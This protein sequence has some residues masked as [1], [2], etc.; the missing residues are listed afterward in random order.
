MLPYSCFR[1]E[2]RGF[3]A[4]CNSILLQYKRFRAYGA[5]SKHTLLQ[6]D[7]YQFTPDRGSPLRGPNL[8]AHNN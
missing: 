1:V 7:T 2:G 3:A 8:F 6:R 5:T 4:E